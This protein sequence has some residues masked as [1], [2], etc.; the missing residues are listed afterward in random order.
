[1]SNTYQAI[2]ENGQIKWLTEAPSVKSARIIVTVLEQT[3]V[4]SKNRTPSATIAGKGK[5]FG[6]IISPI[7]DDQD[8]ECLKYSYLVL[9]D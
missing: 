2:Y 9:V 7:V 4:S 3:T 5:T 8:W 1:M 6:D